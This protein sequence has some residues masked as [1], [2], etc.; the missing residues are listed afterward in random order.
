[1]FHNLFDSHIHTN[2]SPNGLHSA[3]YMVEHARLAGLMGIAVTDFVDC[4]DFHGG[5]YQNRIVH[6]V[7]DTAKAKAAFRWQMSF[8]QGVEI[9]FAESGDFDTADKIVGLYPYDFI[10]CSHRSPVKDPQTDFIGGKLPD[11]YYADLLSIAKWGRF[12]SFAYLT[13][14]LKRAMP[15]AGVLPSLEPYMEQIDAVLRCLAESGKALELS[16]SVLCNNGE[17]TFPLRVISRF[18]E[19]GGEFVT[20]GSDAHCIED[21]G[22]GLQEGMALLQMAGFSY[23]AFYRARGSREPVMLRIV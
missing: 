3:M 17:T 7:I 2:N 19:L 5:N 8:S 14:P 18:R 1:M 4:H 15:E 20:I 13:N 10:I 16:A 9:S 6:S 23:F 22:K 12:D 21:I 11:D